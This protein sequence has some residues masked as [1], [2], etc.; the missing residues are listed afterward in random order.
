MKIAN[1]RFAKTYPNDV[2]QFA[3]VANKMQL[4]LTRQKAK[5]KAAKAAAVA[6]HNEIVRAEN[7][8]EMA[9]AAHAV[10]ELSADIEK[11]VFQDI[12]KRVA[13]D[14]VTHSFNVAVAELSVEADTDPDSFL[15]DS[16]P[17]VR[18]ALSESTGS[19]Y[20]IPKA[21]VIDAEV[22]SVPAKGGS[23]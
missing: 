21:T 18:G 12:K 6:F 5:Q 9:L 19:S 14:S 3:D 11:Q 8:Y 15:T 1:L 2:Q 20:E 22:V 16:T 7:I 23:R 13:F 17:S 4:V 10:Q